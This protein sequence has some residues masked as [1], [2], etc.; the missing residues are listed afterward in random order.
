MSKSFFIDSSVVPGNYS[1]IAMGRC[2]MSK[3]KVV[4]VVYFTAFFFELCA[5]ELNCLLRNWL[6]ESRRQF[7]Q[8]FSE[9]RNCLSNML[10]ANSALWSGRYIYYLFGERGIAGMAPLWVQT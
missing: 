9:V 2:M 4:F 6:H 5:N 7:G 3:Q 1:A 8:T 10:L